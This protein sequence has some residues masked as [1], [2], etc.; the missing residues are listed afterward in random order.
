MAVA[1]GV[2][3][4]AP[5]AVITRAVSA[6]EKVGD[7]AVKAL[8][9]IKM[10]VPICSA[11]CGRRIS[12]RIGAL[13]AN[14]MLKLVTNCAAVVGETCKSVAMSLSKP[15]KIKVSVPTAKVRRTS[16]QSLF[17]IDPTVLFL[18]NYFNGVL[19][20]LMAQSSLPQ[21]AI[22]ELELLPVLQ[23]LA[24]PVRLQLIAILAQEG[25]VSCGFVLNK[26][27]KHKSTLSHHWKVLREAGL[28][29]TTVH[30][31]ERWVTLRKADVEMRFPGLLAMV[32][33]Q[34]PG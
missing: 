22:E 4:L 17:D 8:P 14:V 20:R 19:L 23:A 11:W 27:P 3:M 32:V 12:P 7:K 24:D 6:K 16:G 26:L 25:T 30:G 2:R 10:M 18:S 29:S 33:A 31:R 21:P 13:H 5:M 34:L 28:T 15:A 1:E 9:R